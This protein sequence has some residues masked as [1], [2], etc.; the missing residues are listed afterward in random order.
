MN[1]ASLTRAMQMIDKAQVMT[2]DMRGH[3]TRTHLLDF[4]DQQLRFMREILEQGRVPTDEEKA[5]IGVGRMAMQEFEGGTFGEYAVALEE[6][7]GAFSS[8]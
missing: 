7:D 4:A 2:T 8:L 3:I 5:R 1:S 6:A